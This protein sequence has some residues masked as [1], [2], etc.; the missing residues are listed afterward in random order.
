MQIPSCPCWPEAAVGLARAA[1]EPHSNGYSLT[2]VTSLK[3]QSLSADKHVR[4]LV[5]CGTVVYS[6]MRSWDDHMTR[7]FV[8]V[9]TFYIWQLLHQVGLQSFGKGVT[10]LDIF[11]NKSLNWS[12]LNSDEICWFFVRNCVIY[13]APNIVSQQQTK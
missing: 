11:T 9:K 7:P 6:F 8:V 1:S 2:L 13:S 3:L 10:T 12:L 5:V 4:Y